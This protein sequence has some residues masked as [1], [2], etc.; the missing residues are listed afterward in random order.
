[1]ERWRREPLKIL[2]AEPGPLS[3]AVEAVVEERGWA[4][5]LLDSD[6]LLVLAREP[7]DLIIIDLLAFGRDPVDLLRQLQEVAP[8]TRVVLATE[9]GCAEEVVE[10]IKLGVDDYVRKPFVPS[11][12]SR[13]IERVAEGAMREQFE[14]HLYQFVEEEM[15]SLSFLSRDLV[16]PLP[17]AI[18]DRLSRAGRI[19]ERMRTKLTIAFR[20]AI[21]NAIEHGNL[22]LCSP[23][24][25]E[26]GEE[27]KDRFSVT[28]AKRLSDPTYANRRVF[29]Q[30]SYSGDALTISVR[31]EGNGFTPDL[32]F[33]RDN[34]SS[35]GRGLTMIKGS[36]DEVS[37]SCGG[38]QITMVK[39]LRRS[40][41]R[42][43]GGSSIGFN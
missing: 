7:Y 19:D 24:K 42:H 14:R 10:L 33:K 30:V 5:S 4:V 1:M 25:E 16:C 35:F 23:W 27:G 13:S 17:L 43:E 8:T 6:P 22:E 31:D 37:Y 15:T 40:E 38:R 21:T 28:K 9:N 41:M 29:V 11:V 2:F 39:Y 3:R 20:E 36:M 12:L 18:A 32:A 26:Y 34:L